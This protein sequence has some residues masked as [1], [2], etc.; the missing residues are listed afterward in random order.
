MPRRSDGPPRWKYEVHFNA[1]IHR[2]ECKHLWTGLGMQPRTVTLVLVV[3][4]LIALGLGAS[5]GYDVSSGRTTT[6]KEAQSTSTSIQTVVV[7]STTTTTIIPNESYSV[8][9]VTKQTVLVVIYEP[10][11]VT[12][13]GHASVTYYS[14]PGL[15][16]TTITFIYPSIP[17][18]SNIVSFT[19]VTNS[20]VTGSDQTFSQSISC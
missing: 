2:S 19:T 15:Q 11:C 5:I 17:S 12:V 14:G 4:V 3:F 9:T 7:L 6:V 16:T 1:N 10:T 13:S 20:T 18:G 8:L